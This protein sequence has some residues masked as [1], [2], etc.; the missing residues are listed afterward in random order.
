LITT[1]APLGEVAQLESDEE[2]ALAQRVIL[3]RGKPE[4][5]NQRFFLY[6][7]MSPFVQGELKARSS[8]TTVLGIKQVELRKI[9]VPYYPVP[10]QEKIAAVL[11][12]YDALIR[13]C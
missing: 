5:V 9:R 1:E 12:A 10:V 4:I 2:V 8:G 11:S 6:A 3:L 7:L 13:N